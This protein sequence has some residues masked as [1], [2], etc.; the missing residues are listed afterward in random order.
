[1]NYI[2]FCFSKQ[3]MSHIFTFEF[4]LQHFHRLYLLYCFYLFVVREKMLKKFCCLP[5]PSCSGYRLTFYG[6]IIT[7]RGHG[8]SAQPTAASPRSFKVQNP[9]RP[10]FLARIINRQRL[11]YHLIYTTK[12]VQ[13]L[14][15]KQQWAWN[16]RKVNTDV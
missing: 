12:S 1:M 13:K 8:W 4:V 3:I 7:P 2:K 16:V 9:A 5:M 14:G 10:L 11:I 15:T 6:L